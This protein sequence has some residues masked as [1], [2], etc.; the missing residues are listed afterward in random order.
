M[1]QHHVF[2]MGAKKPRMRHQVF[3]PHDLCSLSSPIHAA[4]SI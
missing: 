3:Q 2:Q 4:T 1:M